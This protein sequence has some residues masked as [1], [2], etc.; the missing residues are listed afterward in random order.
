MLGTEP[1]RMLWTLFVVL[2]L[3]WLV[4][5]VAI[6]TAGLA[7]HLL[8]LLAAVV[9]FFQFKGKGNGHHRIL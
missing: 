5:V 1:L 6:N 8:L 2:L 4:G 9:L 7:I 3:A